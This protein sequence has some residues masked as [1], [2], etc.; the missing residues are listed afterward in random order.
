[1]RNRI[2]NKLLMKRVLSYIK[3]HPKEWDQGA[4]GV[5]RPACGTAMCFAGHAIV[6][7]GGKLIYDDPDS[8]GFRDAVGCRFPHRATEDIGD[9]AARV[10]GINNYD[11]SDLFYYGNDLDDLTRRVTELTS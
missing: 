3:K 7:S 6:M 2:V 1:M 5:Q 4:W 9:A 10:L 8:E 11:A